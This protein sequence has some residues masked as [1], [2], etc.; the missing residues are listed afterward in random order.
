MTVPTR[1]RNLRRVLLCRACGSVATGDYCRN[2]IHKQNLV[3]GA[4][5]AEVDAVLQ[6]VVT[7]VDGTQPWGTWDAAVWVRPQTRAEWV[8]M[9]AACVKAAA[10]MAA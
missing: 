7:L 4:T 6:E 3:T 1:H 10:G 5:S 8:A 2:C 9:A